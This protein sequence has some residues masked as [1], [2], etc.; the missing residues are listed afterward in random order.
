MSHENHIKLLE[1]W[2]NYKY[3]H[4]AEEVNKMHTLDLIDFLMLFMRDNGQTEINILK[5]FLE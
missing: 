1:A 4:V 2:H 5:K 3:A